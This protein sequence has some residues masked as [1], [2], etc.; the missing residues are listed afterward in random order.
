M[1]PISIVAADL[2][3]DADVDCWHSGVSVLWDEGG[4]QGTAVA[5]QNGDG[6]PDVAAACSYAYS[7][8]VMLSECLS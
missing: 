5:E 3:G 2:D 6:R 1:G 8:S 7:V 4:G